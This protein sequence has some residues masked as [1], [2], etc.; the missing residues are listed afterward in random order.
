M[1]PES[2]YRAKEMTQPE[3]VR[4]LQ[5]SACDRLAHVAILRGVVDRLLSLPHEFWV[6]RGWAESYIHF[7]HVTVL[8][9]KSLGELRVDATVEACEIYAGNYDMDGAACRELAGAP[10]TEYAGE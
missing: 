9:A 2:L 6:G 8:A 10:L 1:L 3:I 4:L 5:I 7:G